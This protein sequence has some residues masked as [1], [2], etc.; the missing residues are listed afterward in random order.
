MNTICIKCRRS[1][2]LTCKAIRTIA[3]LVLTMLF[4]LPTQ[5]A[6]FSKIIPLK[7]GK[8]A[9]TELHGRF[10]FK[11][12]VP[13]DG[14]VTFY[15]KGDHYAPHLIYFKKKPDD[16]ITCTIQ[17]E[18]LKKPRKNKVY[19][20]TLALKK[21]TYYVYTSTLANHVKFK[22]RITTLIPPAKNNLTRDTAIDLPVGK[23]VTEWYSKETNKRRWFKLSLPRKGIISV[24]ITQERDSCGYIIYNATGE[25][26]SGEEAL[27]PGTYYLMAP[28]LSKSLYQKEWKGGIEPYMFRKRTLQWKIID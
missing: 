21:G 3:I 19:K 7:Q 9:K 14:I 26:I 12:K 8:W 24:Q 4:V 2:I 18:V 17:S 1:G 23:K 6:P 27:E 28:P 16:T 22:Y 25:E 13:K 10:S 11:I 20:E 15:R 5:A